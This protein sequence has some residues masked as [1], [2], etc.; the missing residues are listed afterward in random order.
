MIKNALY[1]ISI[2]IVVIP[3]IAGFINYKGLNRD[4]RWIFFL[5][6]I[7]VIPQIFTFF[8]PADSAILH[9]SYNLYTII[10]FAFLFF[11][12]KHKYLQNSHKIIVKASMLIYIITASVFIVKE[13][14]DLAF[15]N[16]LVCVNNVIY[17]SWILLILKEQFQSE[18]SMIQK[19]IPFAWYLLSLIIYAPL[20]VIEFAL[21]HY[22]RQPSNAV[23]FNLWIIH[24][25][26]NILL[27]LL[28]AIGLF[29]RNQRQEMYLWP[30]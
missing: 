7:A 12:F 2:W 20:T 18:N 23:L 14:I 9:T 19:Q 10:E 11:I 13:G 21:Y 6:L 5:V 25:I 16:T 27:Y 30:R 29:L 8:L 17:M 28:F 4:S 24:N 22:I 15:L 3:A 26:C 1:Q